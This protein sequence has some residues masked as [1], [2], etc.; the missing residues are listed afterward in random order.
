MSAAHSTACVALAARCEEKRAAWPP[1]ESRER[2]AHQ[3]A[4]FIQQK[5]LAW[6]LASQSWKNRRLGGITFHVPGTRHT[7]L[8][9]A[10]LSFHL[11]SVVFL[12]LLER[13]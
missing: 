12:F 1:L 13:S 9:E 7:R 8:R 4:L 11:P 6:L 10:P 3:S 5:Y 2:A